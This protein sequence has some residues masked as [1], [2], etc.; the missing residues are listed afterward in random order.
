MYVL[1]LPIWGWPSYVYG[2]HYDCASIL[3][4]VRSSPA[5]YR[6]SVM[7]LVMIPIIPSP[8]HVITVWAVSP[9]HSRGHN[10]LSY[11]HP[12]AETNLAQRVQ[13]TSVKGRSKRKLTPR[14]ALQAQCHMVPMQMWSRWLVLWLTSSGQRRHQ[15]C[16]PSQAQSG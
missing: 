1:P 2:G 11:C 15:K 16:S 10:M 5:S 3:V 9:C 8:Y 12:Q 14:Q 6:F 13:R 7:T 4:M